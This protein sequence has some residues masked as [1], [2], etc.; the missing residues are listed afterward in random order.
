MRL[1]VYF[2]LKRHVVVCVSGRVNCFH[3]DILNLKDLPILD[4]INERTKLRMLL[5][6]LLL[7]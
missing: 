5:E 1:I 3:L 2:E 6:Y 4:C 7:S